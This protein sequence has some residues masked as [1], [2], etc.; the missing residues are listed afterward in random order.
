MV[1]RYLLLNDFIQTFTNFVD[2][3]V[4]GICSGIPA[5]EV[6]VS[7]YASID[8]NNPSS[9]TVG[10]ASENTRLFVEEMQSSPTQSELTGKSCPSLPAFNTRQYIADQTWTD[11]PDAKIWVDTYFEQ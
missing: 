7:F 2:F 8:G 6:K 5:G 11:P 4:H 10:Y 1:R 9:F 3:V